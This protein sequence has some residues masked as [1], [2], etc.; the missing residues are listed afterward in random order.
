RH[1]RFGGRARS[2]SSP[3]G[4]AAGRCSSLRGDAMK[5]L[6]LGG[7]GQAGQAFQ[8]L[9]GAA[10]L[11]VAAPLRAEADVRDV[12]RV[13]ALIAQMRPDWVIN[14]SAFHV[15]DACETDFSAAMAVNAVAVRDMAIAARDAGAR[16]LT[17][18]TDYVFDGA[19]A[20]PWREDDEAR[21]LQAYG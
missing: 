18:S 6:L 20:A 2:R 17:V 14:F 11:T 19:R 21:P 5:V 4:I 1:S 8:A 7:H 13:T 9:P 16:F 10:S 15:L 3:S 12:A